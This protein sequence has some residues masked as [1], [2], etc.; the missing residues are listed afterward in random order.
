MRD[1][2][3]HRW[4]AGHRPATNEGCRGFETAEW[5]RDEMETSEAYFMDHN[6]LEDEGIT[7]L[8]SVENH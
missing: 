5:R 4:R 3:G 7:F 2:I 8:R 6:S 1:V